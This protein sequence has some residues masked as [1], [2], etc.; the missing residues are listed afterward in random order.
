SSPASSPPSGSSSTRRDEPPRRGFL[1]KLSAAVIGAIAAIVPLGIS[2]F[3][4][5]DPVRPRRARNPNG[6]GGSSDGFYRVTSLAALPA[7]GEP[8][9]FR[10]IADRDDG[11]THHSSEPVGSVYLRRTAEETVE[12]YNAICP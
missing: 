10:I 4:L 9:F 11:W 6:A 8:R 3:A 1:M 2:L 7:D 12:A 5:F